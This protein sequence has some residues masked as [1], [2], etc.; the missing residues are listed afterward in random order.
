MELEV[1]SLRIEGEKIVGVLPGADEKYLRRDGREYCNLSERWSV[2][3]E[4]E[5]EVILVSYYHEKRT[6]T[7]RLPLSN[8]KIFLFQGGGISF[9]NYELDR[10]MVNHGIADINYC[11]PNFMIR[12]KAP[13]ATMQFCAEPEVVTDGSYHVEKE[14]GDMGIYTIVVSNA[15]F[16]VVG[17]RMSDGHF[18]NG[19][20]YTKVH[21]N[22]IL[23]LEDRLESLLPPKM[24]VSTSL[25]MSEV[26]IDDDSSWA[27]AEHLPRDGEDVVD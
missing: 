14:D 3:I 22:K 20:L 18:F 1:K 11:N 25:P 12:K 15:T 17:W 21:G 4:P 7:R 5:R 10:F 24:I 27:D 19:V 16:A 26:T 23:E 13:E 6:K 8:G 2:S 9:S